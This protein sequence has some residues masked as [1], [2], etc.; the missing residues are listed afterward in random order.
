MKICTKRSNYFVY[1]G[2]HCVYGDVFWVMHLTE[3]LRDALEAFTRMRTKRATTKTKMFVGAENLNNRILKI[4]SEDFCSLFE[5]SLEDLDNGVGFI[6]AEEDEIEWLADKY[7]GV[8]PT[9]VIATDGGFAIDSPDWY[10]PNPL[11][12]KWFYDYC[13]GKAA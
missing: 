1:Q 10:T 5:G 4:P 3:D 9:L 7:G 11:D 8:E 2:D 12:I 6:K 13:F